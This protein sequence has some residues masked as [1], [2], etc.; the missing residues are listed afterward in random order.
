MFEQKS[1]ISHNIHIM[2]CLPITRIEGAMRYRLLLMLPTLICSYIRFTIVI[3][4]TSTVCLRCSS[5]KVCCLLF[6]VLLLLLLTLFVYATVVKK[7][8]AHYSLALQI[9]LWW[10]VARC[11][12]V[13]FG[14]NLLLQRSSLH[15]RFHMFA[16][17]SGIFVWVSYFMLCFL[18][19]LVCCSCFT[20]QINAALCIAGFT[21]SCT[22]LEC[23]VWVSYFMLCFLS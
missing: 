20:F 5:K 22:S 8:A 12:C 3:T 11:L 21:G 18:S 19:L 4:I 10:V 1:W 17:V 16:Y 2:G 6:F 9:W 7:Y 15:Y 14:A 13:V 23:F